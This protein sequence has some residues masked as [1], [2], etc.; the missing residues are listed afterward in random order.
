MAFVRDALRRAAGV[1]GMVVVGAAGVG[2]TRLVRAMAAEWRGNG[3]ALRWV[4]GTASG[5]SIPLGAFAGLVGEVAGDPAQLLRTAVEGLLAGVGSRD[6]LVCV[7]DAHHLDDLSA[8]LV[9]QLALQDRAGLLVTVRSGEASPDAVS[10]LWAQSILPRL[11]LQPLSTSETIEVVGAAL[12][13]P[14]DEQSA[15]SLSDLARGNMLY[16]R[17]VI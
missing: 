3:G 6:T 11:D 7:D 4:T 16:L 15:R 14:V 10:A 5:R 13:G 1:P 2:K 8:V 17:Q 9:L 12:G